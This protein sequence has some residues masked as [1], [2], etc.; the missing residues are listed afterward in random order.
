LDNLDVHIIN[1]PELETLP[2]LII[3]DIEVLE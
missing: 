2:D 1:E 3:D